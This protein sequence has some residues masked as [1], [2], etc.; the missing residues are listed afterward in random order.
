MV[1]SMPL[2]PIWNQARSHGEGIQGQCLPQF[3]SP[4][5]FHCAQKN[6]FETY[7]KNKKLSPPKNAFG[8]QF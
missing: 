3:L 7:N 8:L 6:L 5:K 2:V 1:Q 4:L